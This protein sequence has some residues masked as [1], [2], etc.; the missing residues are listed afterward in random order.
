MFHPAKRTAYPR[1]SSLGDLLPAVGLRIGQKQMPRSTNA[2][3]CGGDNVPVVRHPGEGRCAGVMRQ[4]AHDLT[5]R[6]RAGR[7]RQQPILFHSG[8][9]RAKNK[10]LLAVR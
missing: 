5:R 2:V 1:S 7:P 3:L 9:T 10:Q 8:I 4:F 6:S